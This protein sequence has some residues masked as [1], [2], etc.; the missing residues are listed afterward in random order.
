MVRVSN[1]RLFLFYTVLF[2][3]LFL[4]IAGSDLTVHGQENGERYIFEFCSFVTLDEKIQYQQQYDLINIDNQNK[5][6]S[7]TDYSLIEKLVKEG[8][9]L[10]VEEDL[11]MSLNKVPN[12]TYYSQQ[13]NLPMVGAEEAWDITTGSPEI[14]VA[15]IDTGLYYEHPDIDR[16]RTLPGYNYLTD[17]TDTYDST[18]HGTKVAGIILAN[19]N[20]GQGLSALTWN[21]RVKPL[22]C[23]DENGNAN[24]SNISRAIYDAVD[25]YGAKVINI[26]AGSQGYTRTLLNAVEYAISKNVIIVAAAGNDGIEKANFPASFDNVIGVGSV[27]RNKK[28]SNFSQRRGVFVTAPGEKVLLLGSS[29]GNKYVTDS[30]TSFS[31]PH[32]SAIVALMASIKPD[33]TVEECRQ[34]LAATSEDLGVP[35]PDPEYGYGLVDARKALDYLNQ[36]SGDIVT[37]PLD[38]T[39]INILSNNPILRQVTFTVT[40]RNES[41]QEQEGN[42]I[43]TLDYL[44]SSVGEI[45]GI[46]ILPVKIQGGASLTTEP[47]TMS[48]R[49]ML[50]GE[51]KRIKAFILEDFDNINPL[52]LEEI[53]IL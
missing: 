41:S 2:L 48:Y 27:D 4:S 1:K 23:F 40:I 15:V 36:S 43:L 28:V 46:K 25:L 38:I 22:H 20:N 10:Y 30:G 50:L 13:W 7:T 34:I 45:H 12:D 24:Q 53:I 6:Y 26:S 51:D 32:V 8:K 14:I 21:V 42:L 18:G 31:A 39:N 3:I 11:G 17:S 19:T 29:S 9:V 49:N 52:T 47:V 44:N 37:L 35:G 5:V 16:S 33:L